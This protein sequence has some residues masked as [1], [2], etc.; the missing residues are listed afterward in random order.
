MK[1]HSCPDC[2]A[3]L[4]FENLACGSD[5]AY[6]VDGDRFIA[7]SNPCAN[8]ETIG[9]NRAAGSAGA[10]CSSCAKTEMIPDTFRNDN[11]SLWAE[12]E[13]AKRWVLSNLARWDGWDGRSG[14]EAGVPPAFG[15]YRQGK[16][17]GHDGTCRRCG[18]HQRRRG[19]ALKAMTPM[20]SE[21]QKV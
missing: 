12:S 7:L 21:M 1:I 15:I 17:R 6:N 5:L 4:S 13:L 20:R 2:A 8:R 10:L 14:P 16:G 19:W 3:P 18:D 9:C 11:L